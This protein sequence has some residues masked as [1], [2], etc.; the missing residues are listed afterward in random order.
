MEVLIY[1]NID[2]VIYK[3]YKNYKIM[4]ISII[5]HEKLPEGR[6]R[7]T[8]SIIR[9]RRSASSISPGNRGSHPHQVLGRFKT[10]MLLFIPYIAEFDGQV[11]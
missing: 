9:S 5:Y 6:K 3:S 4:F 8:K 1:N 7:I 11:A 2:N 10:K